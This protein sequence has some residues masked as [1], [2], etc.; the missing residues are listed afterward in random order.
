MSGLVGEKGL[1]ICPKHGGV[2]TGFNCPGPQQSQ[3][4]Y[5]INGKE[6]T[7]VDVV[8]QCGREQKPKRPAQLI[9]ENLLRLSGDE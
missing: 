3:I 7:W 1:G 9:L 4:S 8:E 6:S 2:C 5:S